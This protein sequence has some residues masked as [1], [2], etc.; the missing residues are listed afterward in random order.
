M[1]QRQHETGLEA[2][3]D[4]PSDVWED[5]PRRLSARAQ[6]VLRVVNAWVHQLAA[7]TVDVTCSLFPPE[8]GY[9]SELLITFYRRRGPYG[10]TLV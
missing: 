5:A 8:D 1:Q 4:L 2:Y 6:A 3:K 9:G 10:R 7:G